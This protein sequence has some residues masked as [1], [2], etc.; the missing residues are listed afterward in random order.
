MTEDHSFTNNHGDVL[1]D[2]SAGAVAIRGSVI[3]VGAYGIGLLIAMVSIPLLVRHLGQVGF[4]QYF[5]VLSLVAIVSGLSEGG[6]N[7]LA[8]REYVTKAGASRDWMMGNLFGLRIAL[9]VIGGVVAV[10]F[11]LLA[12]YDHVLVL[13]TG[14]AVIGM[15]MQVAQA[16]LVV[17][18]QTGLRYGWVT[19]I[20]LARQVVGIVLILVF[21]SF[22]AG[23]VPMLAVAVPAGIVA[24]VWTA[25]LVR[26]MIPLRPR[27]QVTEWGALVRDAGVVGVAVAINTVYFRV[28][29]IVMSLMASQV[30][31]GLFS[32]AFQV[33]AVVAVLP[34][35][36]IITAF[37]LL[38]RAAVGD[39][40]RLWTATRRIVELAAILGAG[41]TLGLFVGSEMIVR[42]IG[43]V[44]AV[45]AAPVLEV[46]SVSVFALFVT[47]ACGASLLS[48]QRFRALLIVNV[49]CLLLSV[50]LT[51]LLIP[52]LGALGAAIAASGAEV[53]LAVLC[54]AVLER[55]NP[56]QRLPWG[57]FLILAA[58]CIAAVLISRIP[59]LGGILSVVVAL[60]IFSAGVAIS[61]RF[62]PELRHVFDV[63]ALLGR[64]RTAAGR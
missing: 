13:G 38:S 1:D 34:G 43:G 39:T 62:P 59:N 30:Q 40:D 14:V 7:V 23:V 51:V 46:L 52:V 63:R 42:F 50:G 64:D 32:T 49:I 26:G 29:V 41:L 6:I 27:F 25:A 47:F 2:A 18:L 3:R 36:T 45:A 12:G 24:L 5:T 9:S 54:L 15:L 11:A 48:L 8:T 58:I 10:L 53:A 31:T 44:T 57:V 20:D 16:M 37:P 17:P 60:A 35:L 61:G 19:A 22:G 33:I 56:G 28:T 55:A 21:I 4:G